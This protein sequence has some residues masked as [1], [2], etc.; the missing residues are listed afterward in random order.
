MEVQRG[1]TPAYRAPELWDTFS[2]ASLGPAVDV[3]ALGCLLYGCLAGTP[4]FSP[5]QKLRILQGEFKPLQRVSEGAA[6][7][8][9]DALRVD[10]AQR[11]SASELHSRIEYLL[12]RG[13]GGVGRK[14]PERCGCEWGAR[15]KLPAP[16][17]FDSAL[18][19]R[20]HAKQFESRTRIGE[21]RSR[22]RFMPPPRLTPDRRRPV[23]YRRSL[24]RSS[25]S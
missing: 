15:P 17:F 8:V 1:T 10:P 24:S 13:R 9:A 25:R 23:E 22:P 12:V 11:P 14:E 3:W 6:A 18:L 4:P 16:R 7:L 19:R 2:R 21:I 5:E 20:A